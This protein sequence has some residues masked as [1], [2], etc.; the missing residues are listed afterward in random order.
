MSAAHE[1]SG[2]DIINWTDEAATVISDVKGHVRQISI[3]TTLPST[4]LEIYLNCETLEAKKF[5]IRLSSDGFRI[6]SNTFDQIDD[7]N[8]FPYETPYALLNELSPAY[9]NSFGNELSRALSNL[10]GRCD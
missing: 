2:F 3:S 9:T 6:V 10:E 7:L 4:E 5:T 8:G 1:D